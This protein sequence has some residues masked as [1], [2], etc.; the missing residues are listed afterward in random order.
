MHFIQDKLDVNTFK[1]LRQHGKN[2]G[3]CTG[4]ILY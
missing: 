1:Y 4:A 2:P 3:R